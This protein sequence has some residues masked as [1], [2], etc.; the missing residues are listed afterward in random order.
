MRGN[1]EI[2]IKVGQVGV[3]VRQKGLAGDA[4]RLRLSESAAGIQID[5]RSRRMV[6]GESQ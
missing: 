2:C 1:R 6:K 4:A 3:E 5:F